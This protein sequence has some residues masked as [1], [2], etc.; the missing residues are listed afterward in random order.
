LSLLIDSET[1]ERV[2]WP[3]YG[4][5]PLFIILALSPLLNTGLRLK[6]Y[7]V[8]LFSPTAPFSRVLY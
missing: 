7:Y 8:L 1:L 4:T 2:E 6:F 5:I 3:V